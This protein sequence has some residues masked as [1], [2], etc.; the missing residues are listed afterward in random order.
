MAHLE[1][2]LL[3]RPRPE[4]SDRSWT[5]HCAG[6]PVVR[7]VAAR[8]TAFGLLRRTPPA[9]TL[10]SVP[11][12]G[13]GVCERAVCA[14]QTATGR[15]GGLRSGISTGTLS[16]KL[17]NKVNPNFAPSPCRIQRSAGPTPR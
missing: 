6:N 11:G 13:R 17:S 14:V 3:S 4:D 2:R 1:L 15:Q 16:N 5:P 8:P 9:T 10:D 12:G 7:D